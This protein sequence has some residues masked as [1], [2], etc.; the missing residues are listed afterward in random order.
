ML[1]KQNKSD[2]LFTLAITFPVGKENTP[3]LSFAAG[4]FDYASTDKLT[5]AQVQKAFYTLACDYSVS[6]GRDETT[7]YL[8]GLNSNMPKAL[9]LFNE[10][11]Q[12]GRVSKDDYNKYIEATLKSRKDAKKNQRNCFMAM[13][14]YAFYGPRNDFSDNMSENEMRQ[15][16]PN[17]LL[18]LVGNLRHQLNATVLYYGPTPMAEMEK[19]ISKDMPRK[20]I[21]EKFSYPARPY[22]LVATNEPKVLLAPYEAKNIYMLQC[23][24]ENIPFNADNAPI[25]SLFNNY[26]GAGMSAIVFQELREA[27]GLAYS[28]FADYRMPSNKNDKEYFYTYIITQN[29]KMVD[30]VKE[31]NN[32]LDTMP[33]RDITFEN[34]K[35]NLLKSLASTR[36]QKF[37]ILSSYH[38]AQKLGLN[39]DIYSK[40]YR[41]VPSIT[42][43]DL[44]KFSSERIARKPWTYVIIG[45]EKELDM[46][47][48][49]RYGKLQ[50]VSLE[51][52]FGY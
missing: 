14:R 33:R 40:I 22:T 20:K 43:D 5:L 11:L 29:D 32:L 45:D 21:A 17:S 26:F 27:R 41:E 37:N 50:R 1:Y 28:A 7:F 30:C 46:N 4:L 9:A 19:L 47:A 36:V 34:A 2:D 16:D 39:Y 8:Q 23:Y 51:E 44:M 38:Q 49:S 13:R 24:N 52:A 25:I 6:V 42:L 35:Q 31:Y 12:K 10:L 48:I 3:R 15:A 18:R